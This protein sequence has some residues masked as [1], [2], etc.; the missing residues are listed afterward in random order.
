MFR[1]AYLTS[2]NNQILSTGGSRISRHT[3]S[4]ECRLPYPRGAYTPAMKNTVDNTGKYS[5][6]LQSDTEQQDMGFLE[7][8]GDGVYRLFINKCDTDLR[9]FNKIKILLKGSPVVQGRYKCPQG[10]F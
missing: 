5:V 8:K 1:Q 3:L 7:R 9:K 6:I 2:D 10:F 4:V